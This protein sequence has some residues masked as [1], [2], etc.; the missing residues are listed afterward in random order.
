MPCGS[1]LPTSSAAKI[2]SLR[3][4]NSSGSPA[5]SM[6]AIQYTAASGS[7]ARMLLMNADAM[8]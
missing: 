5:S 2:T 3:A 7:L 4:T 1:A 6:R 8:L